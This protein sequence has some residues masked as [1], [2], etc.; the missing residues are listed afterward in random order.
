M[1][2]RQ[3]TS[4]L[5][6]TNHRPQLR[7]VPRHDHCAHGPSTK[8]ET[9][10][11]WE[12]DRLRAGTPQDPTLPQPPREV[13][14]CKSFIIDLACFFLTLFHC[15]QLEDGPVCKPR[16]VSRPYCFSLTSPPKRLTNQHTK[17]KCQLGRVLPIPHL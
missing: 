6:P 1:A 9:R 12:T 16:G 13:L 17:K 15:N 4:P 11:T 5:P 14:A 10:A 3:G 8:G 2:G 7:G